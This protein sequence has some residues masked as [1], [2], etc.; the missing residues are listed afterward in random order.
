M[1]QTK[2]EYFINDYLGSPIVVADAVTNTVNYQQ[3]QDPFGNLESSI[4]VPSSN[5]EFRYTDK[6]YE[7]DQ[8][9]FYFAAR[10]YDPVAGRFWGR[11]NVKLES[12]PSDYFHANPFTFVANNPMRYVDP[13]GNWKK[14]SNANKFIALVKDFVNNKNNSY[15]LV[16]ERDLYETPRADANQFSCIGLVQLSLRKMKGD[17]NVGTDAIDNWITMADRGYNPV[18]QLRDAAAN[19]EF[20]LSLVGDFTKIKSG[21]LITHQGHIEVIANVTYD[22]NGS[23]LFE[24]YAAATFPNPKL[25]GDT[26]LRHRGIGKAGKLTITDWAKLFG[27]TKYDVK[28]IRID[29]K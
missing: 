16:S 21:D 28:V 7:E 2:S 17:N 20:G 15:S 1:G 22:K 13:D 5:P 11:D 3:Y 9:L 26:G 4:G 8:D 23:P 29:E 19:N 6:E 25:P 24:T 10:Y 27:K 12:K 14:E 18:S